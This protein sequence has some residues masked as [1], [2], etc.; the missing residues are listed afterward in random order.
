MYCLLTRKRSFIHLSGTSQLNVHVS[1][2]EAEDQLD[3][4]IRGSFENALPSQLELS[5]SQGSSSP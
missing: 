3:E 2:S 1:S 5:K 4:S